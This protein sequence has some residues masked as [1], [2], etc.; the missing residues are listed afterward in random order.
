MKILDADKL[1]DLAAVLA[2]AGYRVVAPVR[3]GAQ[4]RMAEWK[5][6]LA[7]DAGPIPANSVKEFLFPRCEVIAR[8]SLDGDS[9]APQPAPVD[10]PKTAVLAVRP[11]DA[12][13]MVALDKV[14]NWEYRDDAWNARREATTLVALVCAAADDECFCT[15][16]GGA[17]DARLGADA[18]LRCADGASKFILEALGEKGQALLA[19]AAGVLADGDARPDPPAS[20]PVRFDSKAVT[21][22][23][24]EN[25]ESPLWR[26]LGLACL[27]CGSCAYACPVCHCFDIQ[28]EGTR[29]EAVR[30]RN[31]DTCGL[32][33]F[34]QHSG[35]H[36]PRPDQAARWRQR[37]MH[38]FRY[39]VERFGGLACTGCG[40]CARLCP[41]RLAISQVCRE[42]DEARKAAAK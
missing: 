6:G 11:C 23:C 27:G 13:A 9:F 30:L 38:K 8:Y 21:D 41:A 33:L 4:V 1:P 19:A 31:W 7:I 12:A 2:A 37:V 29:S 22:W 39:F 3:D 42:I 18:V 25:F 28:D 14:F 40:R 36:N 32:A 35:G 15:S 5:P 16:V 34:T 24:G 20:V 26:D 10:A 17:P